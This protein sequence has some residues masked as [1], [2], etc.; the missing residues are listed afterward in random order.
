M[1]FFNRILTLHI[2]A[3]VLPFLLHWLSQQQQPLPLDCIFTYLS[4]E[5]FVVRGMV[6]EPLVVADLT[7]GA[8][9]RHRT[10]SGISLQ[11]RLRMHGW[12][13]S[14]FD[15]ASRS[16]I[17]EGSTAFAAVDRAQQREWLQEA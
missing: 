17:P 8:P 1:L 10:G 5:G 9:S 16:T 6:Q 7:R 12:D 15:T 14:H 13:L 2:P 11:E 3:Q 4:M